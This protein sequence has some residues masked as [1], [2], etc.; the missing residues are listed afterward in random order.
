MP[1]ARH[2]RLAA[3]ERV[4]I[5]VLPDDG[6]RTLLRDDPQRLLAYVRS[7]TQDERRAVTRRLF[8][9][10]PPQATAEDVRRRV[11]AALGVSP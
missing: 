10:L 3:A 2:Q 1:K 6:L 11:F 5:E 7:A 9:D 4:A 8:P